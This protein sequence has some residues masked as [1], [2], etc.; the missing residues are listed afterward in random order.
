MQKK[1]NNAL[2]LNDFSCSHM[3]RFIFY[4]YRS[5]RLINNWK[6]FQNRNVYYVNVPNGRNNANHS[7]YVSFGPLMSGN[8][9]LEETTINNFLR[10]I[11]NPQ[12]SAFKADISHQPE[13]ELI[14]FALTKVRPN[15]YPNNN[16]TI[17]SYQNHQRETH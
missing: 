6:L 9:G 17:I 10:T 16:K 7:S 13:N 15:R 8:N 11:K 14:C 3:H 5:F 1:N 2:T 12:S 4:F